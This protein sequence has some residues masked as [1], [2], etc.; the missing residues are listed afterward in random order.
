MEHGFIDMIVN[1]M[2]MRD[3]VGKILD[4]LWHGKNMKEQF[5]SDKND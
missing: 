5:E 4:L 3:T 2:E 1:R